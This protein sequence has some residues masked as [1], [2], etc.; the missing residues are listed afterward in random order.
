[1][2]SV[3]ARHAAAGAPVLKVGGAQDARIFV[4][5]RVHGDLAEAVVAAGEDIGAAVEQGLRL[6]RDDAVGGGGVLA[7][8]DD[9]VYGVFPLQ[10]RKFPDKRVHAGFPDDVADK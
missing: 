9:K 8:D 4:Q 1:M 5:K 7:V 10:P 3:H 6:A 2:R